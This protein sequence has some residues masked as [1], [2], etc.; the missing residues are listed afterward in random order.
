MGKMRIP[1]YVKAYGTLG[2]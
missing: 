2:L 1:F